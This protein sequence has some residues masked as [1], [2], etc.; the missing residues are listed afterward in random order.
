MNHYDCSFSLFEFSDH[1]ASSA[2]LLITLIWC[3]A[4]RRRTKIEFSISSMVRLFLISLYQKI[5]IKDADFTGTEPFAGRLTNI[6]PSEVLGTDQHWA[7]FSI[8]ISGP[9]WPI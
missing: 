1:S 7:C 6:K 5:D 8:K 3:A 4:R 9:A 2:A